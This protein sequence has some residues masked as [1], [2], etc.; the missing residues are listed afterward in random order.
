M[1]I[2]VFKNRNFELQPTAYYIFFVFL[3][4]FQTVKT[5]KLSGQDGIKVSS[6]GDK[7]LVKT[8]WRVFLLKK[9]KKRPRVTVITR[10][11]TTI[12]YY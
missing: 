6:R 3:I 5:K 2:C 4:H 9:T 12:S 1:F 7:S 10:G 8:K 11:L